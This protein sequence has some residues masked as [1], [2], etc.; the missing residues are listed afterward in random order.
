M[1]AVVFL[2]VLEGWLLSMLVADAEV[3]RV[4]EFKSVWIMCEARALALAQAS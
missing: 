1:M 3:L 4:D 2:D